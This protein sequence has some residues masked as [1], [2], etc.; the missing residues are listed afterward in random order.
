[1]PLFT[2]QFDSS[3]IFEFARRYKYQDDDIALEAGER[4]KT[5]LFT[6]MNVEQI[7]GWKTKGRGRSRLLK[8]TDDEIADAL[9]LVVD[10]RTDRAAIAVLL[11]LSGVGVPVASAIVTAIYP[12]RFTIIDF[13]ALEALG[14]SRSLATSITVEFYLK[15]L[16]YCREL[17]KTNRVS[18]RELD[19]A[20]WQWSKENS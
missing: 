18:L 2:L 7:F 13:R 1:M 14:I 9:R 11:G 20:L 12:D 16:K 5:G 17:A 10:A 19:R 3:R 8:N 15:Y 4:I 6:R